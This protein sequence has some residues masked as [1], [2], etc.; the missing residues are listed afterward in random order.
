MSK[1]HDSYHDFAA[2]VSMPA[3]LTLLLPVSCCY[4]TQ[5]ARNDTCQYSYCCLAAVVGGLQPVSRLK[6]DEFASTITATVLLQMRRS[7]S[8][9]FATDA[10]KPQYVVIVPCLFF[11][12]LFIVVACL[13]DAYEEQVDISAGQVTL[14]ELQLC[15]MQV[16]FLSVYTL[17]EICVHSYNMTASSAKSPVC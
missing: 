7:H 6:S 11:E 17:V 12:F 1:R 5:A 8:Y 2:V 14:A 16:T 15:A 9:S 3:N 10:Q 4:D 13:Q